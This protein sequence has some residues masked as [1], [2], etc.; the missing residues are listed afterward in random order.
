MLG[1][2]CTARVMTH[3][4]RPY[5][6][7]PHKVAVGDPGSSRLMIAMVRAR[8]WPLWCQSRTHLHVHEPSSALTYSAPHLAHTLQA[9]GDLLDGDLMTRSPSMSLEHSCCA[10]IGAHVGADPL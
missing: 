8:H 10:A 1:I 6:L 5:M 4:V 2:Y 9:D 7:R 3:T